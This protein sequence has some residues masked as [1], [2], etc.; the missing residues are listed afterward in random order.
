MWFGPQSNLKSIGDKMATKNITG[1]AKV[2]IDQ[3]LQSIGISTQQEQFGAIDVSTVG[4]VFAKL[5][6]HIK[7]GAKQ[8]G[9]FIHDNPEVAAAAVT[10]AVGFASSNQESGEANF[11]H[12]QQLQS[13][14]QNPQQRSVADIVLFIGELQMMSATMRG[15]MTNQG[16]VM[17]PAQDEQIRNAYAEMLYTQ[18]MP[19]YKKATLVHVIGKLD[20]GIQSA[21]QTG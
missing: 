14:A 1:K 19:N 18:M 13:A 16:I 5:G 8:L 2:L 10:T 6:P 21:I 4:N 11:Q 7:T 15:E 12:G 9:T 20:R 3:Q 17:K